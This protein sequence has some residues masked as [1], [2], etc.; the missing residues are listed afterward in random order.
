MFADPFSLDF[1]LSEV[2]PDVSRDTARSSRSFGCAL[3][4]CAF[5]FNGRPAATLAALFDAPAP[6]G[7]GD[8]TKTRLYLEELGVSL[9]A[10]FGSMYTRPGR[11]CL[12]TG[13]P[14]PSA[15]L[16]ALSVHDGR[17][18]PLWPDRSGLSSGYLVPRWGIPVM[19]LRGS[20][21]EYLY[22]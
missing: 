14:G 6:S 8:V 2:D 21:G 9:G 13:A 3:L 19:A 18:L 17:F 5:L 16:P 10:V 11:P 12:I 1:D 7:F 22:A 20:K 4:T 15:W